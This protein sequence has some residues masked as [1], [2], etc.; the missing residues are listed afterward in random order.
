MIHGCGLF[1]SFSAMS[2]LAAWDVYSREANDIFFNIHAFFRIIS[3][4]YDAY[5]MT[6]KR[7]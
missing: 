7:T 4:S 2:A 5:M 1:A 6:G 3:T